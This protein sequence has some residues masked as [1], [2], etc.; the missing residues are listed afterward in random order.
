MSE[1]PTPTLT[2]EDHQK[3]FTEVSF[4]LNIFAAT[5]QDL[6]G[7]ATAPVGRIAGRQ[8]ASKLPVYIPEPTLDKVLAALSERL[9]HGFD[10]SYRVNGQ[11]ADMDFGRCAIREACRA[12]G[13][14]PG[15]ELC[16]LFHYYLDGMVNGLLHRPVKSS[17]SQ[18]G[19]R[20]TTRLDT[21]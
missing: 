15:R 21:R 4:L 9:A 10:I 19:D 12:Q 17:L 13:L 20:C 1:T 8:A 7:G 14:A 3:A 18:T 5:V 11:V 6:M 2:I 16:S